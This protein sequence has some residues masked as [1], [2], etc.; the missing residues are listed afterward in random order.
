MSKVIKF[1]SVEFKCACGVQMNIAVVDADCDPEGDHY[2]IGGE[3]QC[4]K[5]DAKYRIQEAKE[6]AP[7]LKDLDDLDESKIP[8]TYC[9]KCFR[10]L[11]SF[12]REGSEGICKRCKNRE[13][14]NRARRNR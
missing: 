2:R 1:T 9:S 5:C 7:E 12:S 11:P 6:E 3:V 4:W 8:T 13:Y 10:L 14:R